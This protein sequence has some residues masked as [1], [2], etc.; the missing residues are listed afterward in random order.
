MNDPV[1]TTSQ[2]SN[3]ANS[4]VNCKPPLKLSPVNSGILT[5]KGGSGWNSRPTHKIKT[6][7]RM[8][9]RYH[10]NGMGRSER[11]WIPRKMNQIMTIEARA[12][13]I[14]SPRIKAGHSFIP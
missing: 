4:G 9:A 3:A 2:N 8:Y 14:N 13:N 6:G 5:F 1:Y 11:L 10:H 12:K 7:T